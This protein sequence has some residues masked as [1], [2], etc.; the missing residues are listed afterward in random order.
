MLTMHCPQC[1]SEYTASASH[2]F[3]CGR[4]VSSSAGWNNSPRSAGMAQTVENFKDELKSMPPVVPPTNLRRAGSTKEPLTLAAQWSAVPAAA[5]ESSKLDQFQ[6]NASA[7]SGNEFSN[8][9]LPLAGNWGGG[10]LPN[11]P[12]QA[13]QRQ[14]SQST[15]GSDPAVFLEGAE[16]L[17]LNALPPDHWSRRNPQEEVFSNDDTPEAP[18]LPAA[19]PASAPDLEQFRRVIDEHPRPLPMWA[20]TVAVLIAVGAGV[21]LS[22]VFFHRTVSGHEIAANERGHLKNIDLSGFKV[23]RSDTHTATV[24]FLALNHGATENPRGRVEVTLSGPHD[25]QFTFRVKV[26]AIAPGECVELGTTVEAPFTG[27]ETTDWQK[28]SADYRTVD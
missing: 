7:G 16:R 6:Q 22:T 15:N 4:P 2:C 13:P 27:T 23:R 20:R 11:L 25:V 8:A 12:Q 19:V 24:R 14:S 1:G 3:R 17:D 9:P 10:S 21:G 18:P 26:P 5:D 28:L